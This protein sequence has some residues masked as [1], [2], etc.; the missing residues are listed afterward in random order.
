MKRKLLKNNVLFRW[1]RHAGFMVYAYLSIWIMCI[2]IA[3][4]KAKAGRLRRENENL[5]EKLLNKIELVKRKENG[6]D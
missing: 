5:R 2:E 6:M 4:L 3:Y 1:V